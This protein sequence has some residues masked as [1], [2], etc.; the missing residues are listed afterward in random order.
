MLLLFLEY[1][2]LI[3]DAQKRNMP[4]LAARVCSMKLTSASWL[5]PEC[6][7]FHNLICFKCPLFFASCRRHRALTVTC[8]DACRCAAYLSVVTQVPLTVVCQPNLTSS[9]GQIRSGEV[10]GRSSCHGIPASENLIQ[11][12]TE[13]RH[14][15]LSSN[16]RLIFFLCETN[17]SIIL[18][19]SPAFS[20]WSLSFL[21]SVG[22]LIKWLIQW[23]RVHLEKLTT[24]QMVNTPFCSYGSRRF[25]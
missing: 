20:K 4:S 7:G 22:R 21:C 24:T 8:L 13:V 18:S 19:S 10:D 25:I 11:I 14:W 23:S 12:F 16:F 1:W 17:F 3:L 15:I 2:C 6:G 9:M 5:R